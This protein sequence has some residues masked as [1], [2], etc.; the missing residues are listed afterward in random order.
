MVGLATKC[1]F[2]LIPCDSRQ[3]RRR[4]KVKQLVLDATSG[5]L[6][7]KTVPLPTPIGGGAVVRVSHSVVSTGTELSKVTLAGQSLIDKARS[8]PDQVAKV[9]DSIR[10]EGVVATVQKVRE[11][12]AAPVSLGYSLS[13]TIL[14]VGEDC[15]GLRVGMRVAC[16]G[17]T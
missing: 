2:A 8:R 4:P 16:G 6:S 14:S 13:G 1:R 5:E 17:T 7:V 12:L 15:G 11:R 10:T 9:L 3:S